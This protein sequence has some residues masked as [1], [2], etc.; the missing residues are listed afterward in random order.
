MALIIALLEPITGA[1]L[2]LAKKSGGREAE[3]PRSPANAQLCLILFLMI[4]FV[5]FVDPFLFFH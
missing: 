2:S 1:M 3:K 4:L 5:F